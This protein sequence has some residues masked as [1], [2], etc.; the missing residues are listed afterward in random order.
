MNGWIK[1]GN[2]RFYPPTLE[3]FMSFVKKGDKEGDCWLWTG[4]H[5]GAQGRYG[6]FMLEGRNTLAHRVAYS[7]FKGAIPKGMSVCHSCD[8]VICVNPAHLW[9]GTHQQNMLDA[10]KKGRWRGLGKQPSKLN[11]EA[12]AA[13]RRNFTG[14]RGELTQLAHEYGV[15]LRTMCDVTMGK[16]WKWVNH[17]T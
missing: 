9:L 6:M 2:G 4:T 8:Y 7:L 1:K 3:R 15:P 16:T 5:S 13:I 10:V 11:A 17:A 14:K 12:V